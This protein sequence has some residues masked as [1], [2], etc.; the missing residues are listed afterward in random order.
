MPIDVRT[1]APD[2]TLRDQNNDEVRLSQFRGHRNVLLVFFPLAF[3]PICHGELCDVRDNLSDFLNGEAQLLTVSVAPPPV[4]KAWA[5]L[6]GFKFPLLADFWP[7]GAVAR[8]YGVFNEEAGIA[9]RGTFLIDRDGIV[10]FAQMNSPREPR[11]QQSWR[12][13]LADVRAG[14]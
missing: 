1:E 3:T 8:R 5:D 7:H 13:A 12:R 9:N 6:E 4:H 10:R 11:D 14:A 2:F